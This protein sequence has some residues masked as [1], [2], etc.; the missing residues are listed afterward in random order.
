MAAL[1][2]SV[3]DKLFFVI[4]NIQRYW[5]SEQVSLNEIKANKVFHWNEVECILRLVSHMY[6]T[7]GV[8]SPRLQW[9]PDCSSV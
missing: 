8:V 9:K 1:F 3:V 2:N 6:Q 7:V 4:L 5:E